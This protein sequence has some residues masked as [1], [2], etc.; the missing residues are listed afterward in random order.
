MI[1]VGLNSEQI[2][3]I[4]LFVTT[5]VRTT[6]PKII[7]GFFARYDKFVHQESSFTR[8]EPSMVK[9]S[10]KTTRYPETKRRG[11]LLF[12]CLTGKGHVSATPFLPYFSE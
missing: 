6:K 5:I 11:R 9:D 8:P 10:G 2:F 3:K 7:S 12:C 1:N 4:L